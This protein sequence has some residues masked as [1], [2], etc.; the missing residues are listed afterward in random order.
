MLAEY[1]DIQRNA[2][3]TSDPRAL[4]RRLQ[5]LWEA[6]RTFTAQRRPLQRRHREFAPVF[7]RLGDTIRAQQ[8]MQEHASIMTEREYPTAGARVRGYTALATV[9]TAAGRPNEALGRIR[10]GCS[11]MPGAYLICDRMAF[12]EVA[13]AHDRAGRADSA[14][15]AYQ[16]FVELRALR[17][18]APPRTLDLVTP[19]IAPAWRRL[20][21][22][23]ESKGENR[24]AI[25]AYERFLD[26]WRDADPELQPMVRAVRER[27]DRLRRAIG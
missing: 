22:L 15:A 2:D 13:E 1:V 20:G 14:I 23:L 21:E 5:S 4:A 16:R 6:N 9:A 26:F 12:L 24:K 19:R 18:F 3:Y 10:D 25:E 8:L 11:T 17:W 27:T 7:A